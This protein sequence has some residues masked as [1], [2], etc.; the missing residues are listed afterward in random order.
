MRWILLA[1]TALIFVLVGCDAREEL[2][3]IDETLP[4]GYTEKP[5]PYDFVKELRGEAGKDVGWIRCIDCDLDWSGLNQHIATV[6]KPRG[7]TDTS[8]DWVP[9]MARDSGLD[10]AECQRIFSFHSSRSGWGHVMV[11]DIAYLQSMAGASL[12]TTGDFV[13]AVGYDHIKAYK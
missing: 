5:V 2:P 13:I 11:I 3:G 1:A 7:Y 6:L 8:D 9:L 10:E 12:D 4:P